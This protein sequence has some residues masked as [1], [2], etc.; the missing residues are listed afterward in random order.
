MWQSVVS[1]IKIQCVLLPWQLPRHTA[2]VLEAK[3]AVIIPTCTKNPTTE[4]SDK[5]YCTKL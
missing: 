4:Q 2:L 1:S 3:V 5:S